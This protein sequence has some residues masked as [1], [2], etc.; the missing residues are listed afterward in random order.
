MIQPAIHIIRET[1]LLPVADKTTWGD[2][3]IPV[4][5]IL[6][7]MRALGLGVSMRQN[8]LNESDIYL[9][10]RSRDQA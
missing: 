4:P 9:G 10:L 1:P 6:L 5:I 3:Y 8:Q 2:T 7:T